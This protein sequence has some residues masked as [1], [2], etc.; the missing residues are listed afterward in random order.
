MAADGSHAAADERRDEDGAAPQGDERP[1]DGQGDGADE[2]QAD[3]EGGRFN[4]IEY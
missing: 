1:D 4:R 2:A 3:A